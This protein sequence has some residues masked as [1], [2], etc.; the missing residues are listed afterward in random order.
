MNSITDRIN[1]VY[2]DYKY[3]INEIKQF[4]DGIFFSF[5]MIGTLYKAP[6]PPG[7][8]KD[9][10]NF[11]KIMLPNWDRVIDERNDEK[12]ACKQI[13]IMI[14]S[15]FEDFI[16]SLLK[17]LYLNDPE[18][19]IAQDRKAR[20]LQTITIEGILKFNDINVLIEDLVNKKIK[21]IIYNPIDKIIYK[22]KLFVHDFNLE[23]ESVNNIVNLFLI[24]NII[25]HNR[26][27]INKEF[28]EKYRGDKSS[29][30]EGI[31]FPLSYPL[32]TEWAQKEEHRIDKI[33][34]IEQ[35]C[36]EIHLSVLRSIK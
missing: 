4:A 34:L 3:R 28:I 1:A 11:A 12:I 7:V 18:K 8:A 13:I 36:E 27:I 32:I 19:L 10:H 14:C 21:D 30:E 25:V 31:E 5:I 26:G 35:I 24:R 23:E 9:I 33:A 29:L 15:V 17:V 16:K 2:D 22:V 6:P 20:E